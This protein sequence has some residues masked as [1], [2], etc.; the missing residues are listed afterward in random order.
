[1]NTPERLTLSR[2]IRARK[3]GDL[4]PS[5]TF[6]VLAGL[7]GPEYKVEI[8]GEAVGAGIARLGT[9]MRALPPPADRHTASA[10]GRRRLKRGRI[11]GKAM[12]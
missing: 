3:L 8:E 4:T 9:Q 7:A 5:S 11:I 12:G 10:L 1:M 2:E 6:L